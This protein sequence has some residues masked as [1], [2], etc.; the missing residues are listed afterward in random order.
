MQR[1]TQKQRRFVH[2][3]TDPNGEG[4]GNGTRAAMVAYG[5]VKT[6]NAAAVIGSE[7]IRKPQVKRAIETALAKRGLTE[8]YGAEVHASLLADE[9]ANIRLRALDMLYKVRGDYAPKKVETQDTTPARAI[10]ALIQDT[11]TGSNTGDGD[12]AAR[13]EEY[14]EHQER[15]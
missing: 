13:R 3:Y 2:E 11:S 5:P 6:E 8:D 7:N 1:L 10:M 12:R 9:E 14:G 4:F 15:A